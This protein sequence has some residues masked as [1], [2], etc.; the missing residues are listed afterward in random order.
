MLARY[1]TGQPTALA[2]L[3]MGAV[4]SHN[5][6]PLPRRAAAA[7]CCPASCAFAAC[8]RFIPAACNLCKA[9]GVPRA[10]QFKA[11]SR[12]EP[13]AQRGG[14]SGAMADLSAFAD[15]G[16]DPKAYINQACAGKTGEE[17]LER[18]A[19]AGAPSGSDRRA[20][21]SAERPG[22]AAASPPPEPPP[23]AVA[24]LLAPARSFRPPPRP[25]HSFLAEL[26]MRLHL[27]A[28]DVGLYLQD[29]ATRAQ[30]RIP[31]AAKELLRIQVPAAAAARF[32]SAMKLFSRKRGL[33]SGA[34]VW[35]AA[36]GTGVC[37]CPASCSS[38]LFRFPMPCCAPPLR[39]M[40]RPCVPQPPPR[41][42]SWRRLGAAA[43]RAW[44][45]R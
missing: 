16:F 43:R 34:W 23:P 7:S 25:W 45:R 26:E 6:L 41:C 33:R 19:A 24:P 29:H 32:V 3:S 30:Q 37:W 42:S 12:L 28:E 13:G 36:C 44:L 10:L 17:P 2:Q 22:P 35:H 15:A 1:K 18:C 31:A 27:S 38:A 14:R 21:K 39:T 4:D 20:W 9:R 8:D 11:G 5:S 40:S